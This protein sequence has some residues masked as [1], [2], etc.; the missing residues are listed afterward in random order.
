MKKHSFAT[1]LWLRA[2]KTEDTF[3][4]LVKKTKF[5]QRLAEKLEKIQSARSVSS[6]ILDSK[7]GDGQVGF[8]VEAFIERLNREGGYYR[9]I[10]SWNCWC[11]KMR[12]PTTNSTSWNF[13]SNFWYN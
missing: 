1:W 5:D 8:D 2:E 3:L 12:S 9:W 7:T 4:P 11:H 13:K 10:F 6:A